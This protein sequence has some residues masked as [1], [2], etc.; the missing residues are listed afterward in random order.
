TTVHC[1]YFFLYLIEEDLQLVFYN[2]MII[3][4]IS[5]ARD[6]QIAFTLQWFFRRIIINETHHRL[7]ARHQQSRIDPFV[8]MIFEITHFP[9]VSTL[10]PLFEP[11]RFVCEKLRFGN[12]AEGEA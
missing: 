4:T 12:A 10:E 8:E 11:R 2:G 3:L 7:C 9:L 6:L 1:S 5:I